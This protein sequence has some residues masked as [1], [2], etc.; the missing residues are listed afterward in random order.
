MTLTRKTPRNGAGGRTRSAMTP[1]GLPNEKRNCG[2]ALPTRAGGRDDHNRRASHSLAAAMFQ[3][4]AA[5]DRR[6]QHAHT[7]TNLFVAQEAA[8]AMRVPTLGE[9]EQRL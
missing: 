3:T 2:S 9:K 7:N 4:N 5:L 1:T 6:Q 8:L